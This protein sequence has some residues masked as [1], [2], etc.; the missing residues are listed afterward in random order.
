VAGFV[1]NQWPESIGM[2]G[3]LRPESVAGIVRNMQDKRISV[4]SIVHQEYIKTLFRLSY[5][6]N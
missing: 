3:R 5:H 6:G 2:G 1:R 4:L